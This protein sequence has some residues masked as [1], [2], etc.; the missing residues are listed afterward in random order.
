[1]N[2]RLQ[3]IFLLCSLILGTILAANSVV[4]E[5][6]FIQEDWIAIVGDMEISRDK[7]LTQLEG[8]S[9]DKKNLLTQKDKDF[10]LERMIEEELLILRAKELGLLRNN[11]IVRGS[12]IQQMIKLIISQNYLEPVDEEQ[13][14]YF[15]KENLGFFALATRLRV[16]QIYFSNIKGSSKDRAYEVFDQLNAG[17]DF[18]DILILGDKSALEIPNS[19]MNLSKIREYIGPTLMNISKS[20]EPGEFSKPIKVSGGHKIIM[21]LEKELSKPED[22]QE[23][24]DKVLKEY[25]RRKDDQSLRLYLEDLKGWYEIKR[26]QEDT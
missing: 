20:L 25:Q 2:E 22:F 9:R 10:V 19:L 24:K 26:S 18:S 23:I 7:Y 21:L 1:M 11:Q 4:K 5:S 13:L 16:Q 14:K 8:L 12:I 15:Y 3:N 17:R 6:K